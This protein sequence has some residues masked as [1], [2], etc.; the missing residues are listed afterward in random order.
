MS[1]AT[2]SWKRGTRQHHYFLTVRAGLDVWVRA[3]EPSKPLLV[4]T[5][6]EVSA[7]AARVLGE[8]GVARFRE[9][10]SYRS[11]WDFG[12]GR[13]LSRNSLLRMEQFLA[14]YAA[15]RRRPSLFFS[16]NGNLLLAWEDAADHTIE[17]EF[18]TRGYELYL[19]AGDEETFYPGAS[20]AELVQRLSRA[21]AHAAS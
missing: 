15:F 17:L 21:D 10:R 16:Q 5:T 1:L 18:S 20:L 12:E 9:F 13:P 4:R 14:S 8:N 6:P 2:R 11:G 19:E 7:R 3:E